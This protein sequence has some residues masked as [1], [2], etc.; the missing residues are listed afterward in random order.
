MKEIKLTFT[1]KLLLNQLIPGKDSRMNL[2]IRRDL[3]KKIGLDQK[4][5]TDNKYRTSEGKSIWTDSKEGKKV[6]FTDGE[7]LYLKNI[8]SNIEKKSELSH[9]LLNFYDAIN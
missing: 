9:Y 6:K 3:L 5:Y 1:E 2:G 4:D 8:L 7:I